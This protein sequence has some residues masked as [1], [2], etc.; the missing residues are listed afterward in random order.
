VNWEQGGRNGDWLGTERK[1]WRCSENRE[2][3]VDRN[4]EQ[5]GRNGDG[6]GTEGNE[7]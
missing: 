4:R 3:E 7:R 1:K 6:L 5:G 2:K